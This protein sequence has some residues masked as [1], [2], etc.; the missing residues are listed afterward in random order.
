MATYGRSSCGSLVAEMDPFHTPQM[1]P[2]ARNRRWSLP[3]GRGACQVGLIHVFRMMH[4]RLILRRGSGK[5]MQRITTKSELRLTPIEI[6]D[7]ERST[8][9]VLEFQ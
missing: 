9:P 4:D 5:Q 8:A 2:E 1:A 6:R 3:E 7:I